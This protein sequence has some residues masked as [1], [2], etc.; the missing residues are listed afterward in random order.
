MIPDG[1]TVRLFMER[2]NI[3]S[4]LWID[5]V[6]T[7]RQIIELSTPHIYNLTGKITPGEHTFTL[8]IDNRNLLNLDTMAS[9]YSVDTQ[10]YWNGVI[11]RI[12]LQYEE[13]EHI[14]SIQV[15]TDDKGITLKIVETSDVHS[16]FKN[17]ESDCYRKCTS[18]K[19]IYLEKKYLKRR[20]L[21]Q[22]KS[23]ISDT[24]FPK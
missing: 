1:K 7:D 5:G 20:C 19:E 16:P 24:I 11:G 2:V 4:E 22:N 8:K 18:P 21:I 9:G 14:D 13:K 6:K 10:G 3:A 23:I 12:E 17:G 15:Y